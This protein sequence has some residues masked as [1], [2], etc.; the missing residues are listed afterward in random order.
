MKKTIVV[1]ASV[2]L[3]CFFINADA[4]AKQIPKGDTY[5][6]VARCDGPNQKDVHVQVRAVTQ[7]E[8]EQMAKHKAYLGR[9]FGSDCRKPIIR[10]IKKLGS[11]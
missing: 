10:K 7:P 1:C 8:A 9:Y 3:A 6:V 4:E 11:K 2:L 5:D